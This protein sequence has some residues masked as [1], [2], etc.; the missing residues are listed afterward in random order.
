[1]KA[2]FGP[3]YRDNVLQMLNED[4][5]TSLCINDLPRY[6]LVPRIV[7]NAKDGKTSKRFQSTGDSTRGNSQSFTARHKRD[8]R[9]CTACGKLLSGNTFKNGVHRASEC[10]KYAKKH[11]SDSRSAPQAVNVQIGTQ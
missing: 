4:D 8:K 11:S 3:E 6:K 1:M 2:M 7:P 9:P 10:K 5:V